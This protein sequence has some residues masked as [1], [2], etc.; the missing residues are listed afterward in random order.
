MLGLQSSKGLN[1]LDFDIIIHRSRNIV[2]ENIVEE[3]HTSEE[4]LSF[5]NINSD[6]ESRKPNEQK[7][8]QELIDNNFMWTAGGGIDEHAP[9]SVQPTLFDLNGNTHFGKDSKTAEPTTVSAENTENYVIESR[10]NIKRFQPNYRIT[11]N[12]IGAGTQGQRFQANISAITLLKQLESENRSAT[13]DEQTVLA[14]YVGWGGL[15]EYFK[16][17]NPHYDELKNLLTENEYDS[18]RASTLDSF[19]TPPIIIDSIYAV[20]KNSG[21]NGG[22]ILE[23][24]MGIGNFFGKIPDSISENS[25]LYGVEIDSISGRISKQLYPNANITIDGFEKTRFQNNSFDVVLGN[26]PFGRF[27]ING[28]KIHDYFFMKSLDKVKPGGIIAFVTSTGTLDKKDSSFREKLAKQ[29]DFLGAIRLPSQS[30]KANAGT[31]VD[32][33]IIFLKKRYYP[34]DISRDVPDWVKIGETENGIAVNKYFENNPQMILGEMAEG[35]KLYGTGTICMPTDGD[36]V[37]KLNEAVSNIHAEFTAVKSEIEPLQNST[38]M[39][40]SDLRNYSIFSQNNDI[41]YLETI[42]SLVLVTSGAKV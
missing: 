5:D 1:S 24:A 6:K 30:F 37:H 7:G 10:E 9:T 31:D 32:A 34:I 17:S 19:Y 35:N 4:Q 27:S 11:D 8:T 38:I 29:A 26:V 39:P 40:Q 28:M 14:K 23:P 3:K 42:I 2:N 36:L 18:A 13:P 25:K 20:L 15:S 16:E 21:F 41:Y 33:D 22:N 12:N